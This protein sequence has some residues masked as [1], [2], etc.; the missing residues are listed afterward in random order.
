MRAID[1]NVLVRLV[2]RDDA[3]QVATSERL[4]HGPYKIADIGCSNGYHAVMLAP[5]SLL[6]HGFEVL[7]AIAETAR[8]RW[9]KENMGNAQVFVGNADEGELEDEFYDVVLCLYFTP[10]NFRDPSGDL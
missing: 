10:G 5:V 4:R 3:K 8:D 6:Y 1:T 7:P 9:Q 2:S